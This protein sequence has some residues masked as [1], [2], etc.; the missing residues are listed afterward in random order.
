MS[1]HC[2]ILLWRKVLGRQILIFFC[3]WKVPQLFISNLPPP[4]KND[5][6]GALPVLSRFLIFQFQELKGE[7]DTSL[8]RRI[9]QKELAVVFAL[10]LRAGIDLREYVGTSPAEDWNLPYFND[11]RASEE[12]RKQSGELTEKYIKVPY[13][14]QSLR[15]VTTYQR[16]SCHKATLAPPHRSHWRHWGA[17]GDRRKRPHKGLVDTQPYCIVLKYLQVDLFIPKVTYC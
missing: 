2:T 5:E 16:L 11:V 3:L 7:T 8:P 6:S 4:W 13:Y 10:I 12:K 15:F 14:P 17:L 9:V 1:N